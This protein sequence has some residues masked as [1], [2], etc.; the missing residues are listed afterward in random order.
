LPQTSH[1]VSQRKF[2]ELQ[3]LEIE[4]TD[5]ARI[6]PKA[7]Y[8]SVSLQVGGSSN[9]SYTH[10]VTTRTICGSS[11]NGKWYMAKQEA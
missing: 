9:L 8:G 2:L 4:T 5:D 3:G 10:F 6:R 1:L 7:A 11:A